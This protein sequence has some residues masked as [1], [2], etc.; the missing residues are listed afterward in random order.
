MCTT[1]HKFSQRLYSMARK[2]I[3]CMLKHV[4]P[5][6]SFKQTSVYPED[7]KMTSGVCRV[8]I[9]YKPIHQHF[10]KE[11]GPWWTHRLNGCGWGVARLKLVFELPALKLIVCSAGLFWEGINS[12]WLWLCSRTIHSQLGW[13]GGRHQT[14]TEAQRPQTAVHFVLWHRLCDS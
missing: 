9:Q 8:Q 2:K 1:P 12:C 7:I 4:L 3:N 6:I 10:P 14:R 5:V 11:W 13:N